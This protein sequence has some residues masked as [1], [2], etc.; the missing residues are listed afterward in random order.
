M[1][2]L[3]KGGVCRAGEWEPYCMHQDTVPLDPADLLFKFHKKKKNIRGQHALG[4]VSMFYIKPVNNGHYR[5]LFP[6]FGVLSRNLC[7]FCSSLGFFL[8][9]LSEAKYKCEIR[10]I[11]KEPREHL[12]PVSLFYGL[13][14]GALLVQYEPCP[15]HGHCSLAFSFVWILSGCC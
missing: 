2:F 5:L 13:S 8:M 4:L 9:K 1:F 12:V 7:V 14:C 10:V 6:A 15:L 3:L 11:L